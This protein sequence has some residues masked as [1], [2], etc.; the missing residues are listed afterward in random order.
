MFSDE[1]SW[2]EVVVEV[3]LSILSRHSSMD[4]AVVNTVFTILCPVITTKAM[5][6]LFDVSIKETMFIY[7]LKLKPLNY[8]IL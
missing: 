5:Q 3:L 4:R 2:V 1:P 7:F 6:L 8:G